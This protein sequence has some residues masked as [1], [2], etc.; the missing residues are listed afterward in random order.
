MK[1]YWQVFILVLTLAPLAPVSFAK[2]PLGEAANPDA[3]LKVQ[4]YC[5]DTTKLGAAE[6]GDVRKFIEKQGPPKGLLAKLPWKLVEN[7]AQA[8]AVI[9]LKFETSFRVTPSGGSALGTGTAA[10]NSVPEGTYSAQMLITD[11]S[12][13]KPLYEVKGETVTGGRDRSINNPFSKLIR[14]LKTLSK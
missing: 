7:C 14:D 4:S 11:R 8:D 6:A 3:L 13:Q 9:S 2:K 1:H 10:L 12:S 5:I